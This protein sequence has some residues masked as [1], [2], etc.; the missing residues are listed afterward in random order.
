MGEGRGAT[1]GAGRR[2]H[3]LG[4][5]DPAV[6]PL[7]GRHDR[8]LERLQVLGAAAEA[9]ERELRGRHSGLRRAARVAD[10]LR[11]VSTARG[12]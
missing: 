8:A 1:E 10:A 2:L 7:D 12:E 3:I 4:E 11:A 9:E 5:G 6:V